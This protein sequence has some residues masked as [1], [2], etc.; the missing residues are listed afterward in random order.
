MGCCE[1]AAGVPGGG[2]GDDTD[3]AVA[4]WPLWAMLTNGRRYGVDLVVWATGV[5]P[6]TAWLGDAL[7]TAAD[8][9]VVV[10]RQLRTNVE[11]VFAAGDAASC[12][13]VDVDS[14]WFQMRLWTQ[15][16]TTHSALRQSQL[17]SAWYMGR[18]ETEP[19][20]A[21]LMHVNSVVLLRALA[22]TSSGFTH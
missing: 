12:T 16:R 22:V 21:E 2:E 4:D 6:N 1:W 18:E 7:A 17:G 15:V 9:G 13:W 14:N 19:R 5:Q 8:G 11:G 3:G 10:D 20:E